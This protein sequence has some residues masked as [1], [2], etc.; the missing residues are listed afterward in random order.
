M[1]V[2][3]QIVYLEMNYLDYYDSLWIVTFQGNN[4]NFGIASLFLFLSLQLE[5]CAIQL[6]NWAVTKNMGTA[7][8]NMQK[9]KGI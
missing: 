4:A 7:I 8:T 9:A 1:L 5:E 6:W 2:A 3:P